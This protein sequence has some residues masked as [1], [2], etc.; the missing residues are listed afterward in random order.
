MGRRGTLPALRGSRP[1]GP[2]RPSRPFRIRLSRRL[3]TP[4]APNPPLRSSRLS[5]TSAVLDWWHARSQ[6][7]CCAGCIP[8]NAEPATRSAKCTDAGFV[9]LDR[10]TD[11][12]FSAVAEKEST[13]SGDSIG[14]PA[15]RK[16]AVALRVHGCP[17]VG[18]RPQLQAVNH[19]TESIPNDEPARFGHRIQSIAA[20]CTSHP[21][22][23]AHR[24]I[25]SANRNG[26]YWMRI[27]HYNGRSRP[28]IRRSQCRPLRKAF[29]GTAC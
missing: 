10:D 5:S 17:Q 22:R 25:S 26:D 19:V 27:P 6:P 14:V 16:P 29:P 4:S 8:G 1:R 28:S 15:V 3:S 23:M 9:A 18:V 2:L 24:H 7:R 11:A 13:V 20:S 12:L 21:R